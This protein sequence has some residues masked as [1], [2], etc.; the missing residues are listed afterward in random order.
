MLNEVDNPMHA[1]CDCCSKAICL[2]ADCYSPS[3]PD[4]PG[5]RCGQFDFCVPC[6]AEWENEEKALKAVMAVLA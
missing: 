1:V 3:C 5:R 4:V 6:A 2:S